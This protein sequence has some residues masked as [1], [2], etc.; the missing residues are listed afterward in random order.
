MTARKGKT[1]DIAQ[2][3]ELLQSTR[4]EPGVRFH[5]QMS[6]APWK[7]ASTQKEGVFKMNGKYRFAALVA[8][9]LVFITVLFVTP[10]GS[11]TC[12]PG[13]AFLYPR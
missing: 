11:C 4:P 10:A 3:E 2:I 8:V 1:P 6:S 13:C 7:A 9:V 5:H 12:Q